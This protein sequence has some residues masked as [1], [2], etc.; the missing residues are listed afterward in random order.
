MKTKDGAAIGVIAV[1]VIILVVWMVAG[2]GFFAVRAQHAEMQAQVAAD[3]LRE[4]QARLEEIEAFASETLESEG[5]KR[6]DVDGYGFNVTVGDDYV[7]VVDRASWMILEDGKSLVFGFRSPPPAV[8]EEMYEIV[9]RDG[10]HHYVTRKSDEVLRV[11]L[12]LTSETVRNVSLREGVTI[13]DSDPLGALYE[14]QT[15]LA[16]FTDL[17]GRE[18]PESG[19]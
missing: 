15:L 7:R 12:P 2:A 16:V 19:D 18:S 9:A 17:T 14:G 4:K 8:T 11:F 5:G 6:L 1:I 10:S 3:R 13:A